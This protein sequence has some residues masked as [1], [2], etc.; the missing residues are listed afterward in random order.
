[1]TELL[2]LLAAHILAD[3]YWQ[4]TTWVVQ[5]RAKSFKSRFFYYHI[6]V[7][8][9]ASYVLLGYWANPWPAIGLAIAHG[10]IDLVKLHFD[11]TSSTKW[12]IADQVLHL[13]SI[14]TAAG[15]LTGHTQLAINNLMEWYR[16]PTYLAILA[17]VLLCLNPVSFLVG[18]LTKP[19]R[20]ELERLVPEADDNLA[21]AGRWI[22]MSERL[23]IFIFVLISQFSA[24]GFLIAA[25][26]LLRFNDKA[27]ES[28]PSA[29]ITKKSEYVLVG[30]LMS[31][32]CAIILAL[33]TKIFQNI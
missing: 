28:I 9:V 17:G 13:L 1:M 10:I 6:G 29:Y 22:G 8:L 21:N 31:Y 33:L 23:L 27:S 11:R 32:T 14:L 24:I 15:I 3:F 12:F 16:Q 19:W 2:A 7:V 20:I 25:K 18:M 30:T 4:P 26:S 5:K